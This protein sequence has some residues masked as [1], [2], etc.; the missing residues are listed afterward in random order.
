VPHY[1]LMNP[2]LFPE[3]VQQMKSRSGA[4]ERM[5]GFAIEA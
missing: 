4:L 3:H 2:G 1:V 5:N